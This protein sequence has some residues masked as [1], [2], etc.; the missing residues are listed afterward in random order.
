MVDEEKKLEELAIKIAEHGGV[1]LE[2]AS[3]AIMNVI[4]AFGEV[5]K[6]ISET[7]T[8]IFESI[9]ENAEL[10]H[11]WHVN[12]KRKKEARKGWVLNLDTT[13]PSQVMMNKP[14]FI[15]RKVVY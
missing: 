8:S 15:V 10:I 14:K 7:F 5:A 11:K 2:D 1:S 12:E 3:L 9:K 13:K 4:G 6:V